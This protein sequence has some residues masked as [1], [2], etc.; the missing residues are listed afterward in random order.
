VDRRLEKASYRIDM[1]YLCSMLAP[2]YRKR[3]GLAKELRKMRWFAL[4]SPQR[5]HMSD[6]RKRVG[7]WA[8]KGRKN[9]MNCTYVT[10]KDTRVH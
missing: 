4:T 5:T 2:E 9:E 3:A 1:V 10:L 8:M 7:H 6:S